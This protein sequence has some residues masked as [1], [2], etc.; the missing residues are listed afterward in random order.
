MKPVFIIDGKI[1][2]TEKRLSPP[3]PEVPATEPV[4]MDELRKLA[5]EEARK[6]S[7]PK[8]HQ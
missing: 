4:E 6:A 3:A 7:T 8:N 1:V 5:E 2:D